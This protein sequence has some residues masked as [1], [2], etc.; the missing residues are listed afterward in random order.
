MGL[1]KKTVFCKVIDEIFNFQNE[2]FKNGEVSL[3]PLTLDDIAKN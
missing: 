3:K 2:F 1:T